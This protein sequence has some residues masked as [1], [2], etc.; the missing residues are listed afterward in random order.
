MLLITFVAMTRTTAARLRSLLECEGYRVRVHDDASRGV[1]FARDG[2]ADLIVLESP[3]SRADALGVLRAIRETNEATPVLVLGVRGDQEERLRL[4]RA[5]ADDYIIGHIDVEEMIVR[6]SVLLRRS[7]RRATSLVADR[8]T[9]R[10]SR[11]VTVDLRQRG[12]L[13]D[14]VDVGLT[15]RQYDVLMALAA[16]DGEAVSREQ[17]AIDVWG[18]SHR[19]TA[20]VLNWHIQEIRRRLEDDP[21]NPEL[22][23]TAR[24]TGYR[25]ALDR[26]QLRSAARSEPGHG[27]LVLDA[28]RLTARRLG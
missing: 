1:A 9:M 18:A 23:V 10:L 28:E 21:A 19:I 5:G 17:L 25:L 15:Q 22:I 24:R 27:Q 14:G 3:S 6:V 26:G 7:W 2:T 12:A 20:R 13:R 11:H 8:G 4:L 16:H